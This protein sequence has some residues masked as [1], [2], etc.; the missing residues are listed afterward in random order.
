MR[1]DQWSVCLPWMNIWALSNVR[2]YVWS[3]TI[4][5]LLSILSKN[6]HQNHMLKRQLSWE[7][8]TEITGLQSQATEKHSGLNYDHVIPFR[9]SLWF[10]PLISPGQFLV[11][12]FFLRLDQNSTKQERKTM[13]KLT[14]HWTCIWEKNVS[15]STGQRSELPGLIVCWPNLGAWLILERRNAL[16]T[17]FGRLINDVSIFAFWI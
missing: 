5:Q 7:C 10:L 11:L 1:F 16:L 15:D 13:Y 3:E 2:S 6:C 17:S 14:W 4:H 8:K 9:C 12:I